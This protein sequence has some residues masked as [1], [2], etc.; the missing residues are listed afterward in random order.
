MLGEDRVDL[1]V[2][3]RCMQIVTNRLIESYRYR[4]INIHRL[5]LPALLGG[6]GVPAGARPR[7][8][9]AEADAL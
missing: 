3:G 7:R 6:T 2:L 5:M 4:L 8:S 9:G 1:V